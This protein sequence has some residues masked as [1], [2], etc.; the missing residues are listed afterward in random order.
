[1]VLV[2]DDQGQ[3]CEIFFGPGFLGLGTLCSPHPRLTS[4]HPLR[5]LDVTEYPMERHDA[6]KAQ[7]PLPQPTRRPLSQPSL[8]PPSLQNKSRPSRDRLR[9]EKECTMMP[10]L[11][12]LLPP[13]PTCLR[14]PT[15]RGRHLLPGL[16][17]LG[18]PSP[19]PPLMIP[20]H[21]GHRACVYLPHLSQRPIRNRQVRSSQSPGRSWA[22][23]TQRRVT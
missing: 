15:V 3:G 4:S 6:P 18:C 13:S 21:L 10:K 1:M 11:C 7:K 16:R 2:T 19:H 14:R 12:D 22:R 23:S 5:G 20:T 17:S 8:Y 9:N